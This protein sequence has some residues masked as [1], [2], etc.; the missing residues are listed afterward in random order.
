MRASIKTEVVSNNKQIGWQVTHKQENKQ[1]GEPVVTGPFAVIK[2]NTGVT[3]SKGFQA[4]R[5]DIGIEMPCVCTPGDFASVK[6]SYELA[7]E[8]IAQELS[9]VSSH[10]DELLNG[11]VESRR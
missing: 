7:Y 4:V 1:V 3:I 10:L 5:A 8:F 6:G 2:V 9:E 11:L